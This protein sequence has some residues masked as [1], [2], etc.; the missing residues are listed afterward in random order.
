MLESFGKFFNLN[1]D[2]D[3]LNNQ[4][5]IEE[6]DWD[7]FF[8]YF[9]ENLVFESIG[10]PDLIKDEIGKNDS[11]HLEYEFV[12]NNNKFLGIVN[13]VKC[14]TE[15]DSLKQDIVKHQMRKIE[16]NLIENLR[17]CYEKNPESFVLKYQFRDSN[18]NTFLSK[19]MGNLA[20]SVLRLAT[21]VFLSSVEKIGLANVFCFEIHVAKSESRRLD[22]Y[23]K[24]IERSP[25]NDNF[26]NEY[27]DTVTDDKYITYY[28]WKN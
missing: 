24:M 4:K 13:A 12:I 15:I 22:L 1:K 18:N 28:R 25:V 10:T 14:K 27:V 7:N 21:N 16:T 6:F 19:K 5:R 11:R 17:T 20:F 26:P 8:T 23:K 2:L 3:Y 9:H